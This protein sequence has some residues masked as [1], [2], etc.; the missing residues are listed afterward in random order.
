MR[1]I[2]FTIVAAVFAVAIVG[3]AIAQPPGGGRGGM[4]GMQ[5]GGLMILG[6]PDVQKDLKL[7]DAQKEKLNKARE[8]GQ[9]KMREVFGMFKEDPDKGKA[10]GK[11][12]AEWGEK[13]VKQILDADQQKRLKQIQWQQEGADAF[14]DKDVGAALKLT[15]EQKEKIKGINEEANEDRR[16]IFQESRGNQEEIRTKMAALRKE[17]MERAEKVLTA[18]QQKSFT[19]LLGPKFE[20]KIEMPGMGQGKGG[21]NKDKGGDKEKKGGEKKDAEKPKRGDGV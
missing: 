8:E 4:R 15:D 9:T 5:G 3:L 14:N 11:E 13:Q 10:A 2:R 18:D 19:A 7:T 12:L 6:S 20:G 21:R 16:N 17:T 1:R